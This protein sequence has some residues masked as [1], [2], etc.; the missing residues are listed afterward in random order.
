MKKLDLKCPRCGSNNARQWNWK[1][2]RFFNED[3]YKKLKKNFGSHVDCN[4]SYTANCI[5]DDCDYYF[6]AK[7]IIEIKCL[8]IKY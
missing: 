5:C 1:D 8:D 4:D 6:N 2:I 7:V 3:F